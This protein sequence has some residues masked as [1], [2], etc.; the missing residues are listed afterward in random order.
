MHLPPRSKSIASI[1]VMPAAVLTLSACSK[2]ETTAGNTPATT[3]PV[4]ASETAMSS[5]TSSSSASD[6]GSG[7]DTG[8][9]SSSD[10]GSA[11]SS[12]TGSASESG[13]ASSSST[14]ESGSGGTQV[15]QSGDQG[16]TCTID[17]YGLK[18]F[19]L[20]AG[21]VGF[22]QSEKEDNPFRIAE[23]SRSRTRLRSSG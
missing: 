18:P 10:T 5:D 23:T 14:G 15:V 22:S 7:S 12:D 2:S 17:Q 3:A 11:S 16:A 13:T 6:T 8:S 21:S 19:D 20:K 1:A 9:A 4:S